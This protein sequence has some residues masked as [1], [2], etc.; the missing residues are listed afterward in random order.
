MLNTTGAARVSFCVSRLMRSPSSTQRNIAAL[1]IIGVA[2]AL[3]LSHRA[4]A[5]T[6]L[7]R[8]RSASMMLL[9]FEN[10]TRWQ[11]TQAIVRRWIHLSGPPSYFKIGPFGLEC[12]AG[13]HFYM[14]PQH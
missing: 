11:A 3:W 7:G 1:L 9:G 14:E 10:S 6:Q 12:S 13:N 4:R 2:S 8:I 5:H